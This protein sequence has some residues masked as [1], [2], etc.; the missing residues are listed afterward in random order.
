MEP[1]IVLHEGIKLTLGDHI[2]PEIEEYIRRGNYEQS[3]LR[4]LRKHL[5][6]DDVVLELG[7]GIG[8]ISMQCAQVVGAE[9]VF[10]YEANPAL[11]SHIRRNYELNGVFPKL[12]ICVLGDRAGEID[13]FV[14]EDYWA[15]S[16]IRQSPTARRIRVPVRPLNDAIRRVNPSFLI[17]DIEGGEY[18]LLE[19]IDFY[20][21]RKLAME[22][23]RHTFEQARIDAIHGR[24]ANAGFIND[25]EYTRK[26]RLFA[27]RKTCK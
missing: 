17:V 2:T 13:F 12:E 4:A 21:I 3:E 10:A 20:N 5:E 8:F 11:E 18:D 14:E 7:A 26:R 9:R 16:T 22:L 27:E 25:P 6:P 15:S 24:L 23:H 1:Q 19:Q